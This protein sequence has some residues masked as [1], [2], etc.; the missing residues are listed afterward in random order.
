[1]NTIRKL[2][3]FAV[4]VAGLSLLETDPAVA[5]KRVVTEVPVKLTRCASGTCVSRD[6]MTI[7][8]GG[9]DTAFVDISSLAPD[10]LGYLVADAGGL[11]YHHLYRV[12]VL[13][14]NGGTADSVLC[15]ISPTFGTPPIITASGTLTGSAAASLATARSGAMIGGVTTISK[16]AASTIKSVL[17]PVSLQHAGTVN[18]ELY[19]ARFLR[20]IISGDAQ[21][22]VQ[23]ALRIVGWKVVAEGF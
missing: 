17:L 22:P 23:Y 3:L 4:A 12:L 16:A 7:A 18:G 11:L 8:A 13:R 10:G 20:V 1:M 5:E 15:T 14:Y 21:S 19:G 9:A 2:A 6:T